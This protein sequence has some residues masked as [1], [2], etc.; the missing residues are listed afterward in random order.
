[1]EKVRNDFG[2]YSPT[3]LFAD[4]DDM[5]LDVG[6]L[7]LEK[8]GYTVLKA[9]DGLEAVEIFE[10][11]QDYID[12]VILEMKM[13]NNGSTVFYTIKQIDAEARVILVSGFVESEEI[14]DLM[15]QNCNGF[16]EKPFSM[17]ILRYNVRKA[18]MN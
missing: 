13:P 8:L 2:D 14:Q 11:N 1:M 7:M 17:D 18:L 9:H 12:F 15:K 5:C 4:D 10:Q 16:I 6:A 3:I